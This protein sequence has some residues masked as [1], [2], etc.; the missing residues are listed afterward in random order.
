MA[1]LALTACCRRKALL[2]YF[3]EHRGRCE[4]PEELCDFCTD[5]KVQK[6]QLSIASSGL[7]MVQI[8]GP[9]LEGPALG[10]AQ[11]YSRCMQTAWVMPGTWD[12]IAPVLHCAEDMTS[13]SAMILTVRLKVHDHAVI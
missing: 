2:A 8:L 10:R 3:G 6:D 11:H 9:V 1:D 5:L 4:P 12:K 13:I 7:N